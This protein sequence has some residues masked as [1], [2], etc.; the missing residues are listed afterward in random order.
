[1][2]VSEKLLWDV[3]DIFVTQM[4]CHEV[5]CRQVEVIVT[6]RRRTKHYVSLYYLSFQSPS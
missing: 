3:T 5:N 4:G 6:E 2:H 1:V